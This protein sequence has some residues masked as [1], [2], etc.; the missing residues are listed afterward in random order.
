M[1]NLLANIGNDVLYGNTVR[2]SISVIAF[3]CC[4]KNTESFGNFEIDPTTIP[5]TIVGGGQVRVL[6]TFRAPVI[7][8]T[9]T[10]GAS[11]VNLGLGPPNQ[12]AL[13]DCPIV[14]VTVINNTGSLQ[15]FDGDP[16]QSRLKDSDFFS[17]MEDGCMYHFCYRPTEN[18]WYRLCVLAEEPE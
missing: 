7:V 15:A 17:E 1:A 12:A 4:C 16:N 11:V 5:N 2:A 10:D 18:F 13:V 3:R 6:D 14:C 8:L 9:D